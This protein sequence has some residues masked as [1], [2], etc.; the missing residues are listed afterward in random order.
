[1]TDLDFARRGF[2]WSLSGL[3]LALTAT[4]LKVGS[5]FVLAILAATLTCILGMFYC[6]FR[7]AKVGR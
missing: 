2:F 4:T 6:F 1:M 7:A 3:L 5:E